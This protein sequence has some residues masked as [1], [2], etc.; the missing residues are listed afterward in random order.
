ALQLATE[1]AFLLPDCKSRADLYAPTPQ[2]C[3]HCFCVPMVQHVHQCAA[4]PLKGFGVGRR[5]LFLVKEKH[6]TYCNAG[7]VNRT[8][9]C[10][11]SNRKANINVRRNEES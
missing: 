3:K 4:A 10:G 1:S 6:G 11:K 5:G 7:L 9:K 8:Y 2:Y